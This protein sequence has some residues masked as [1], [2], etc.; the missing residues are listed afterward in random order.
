MG[1]MRNAPCITPSPNVLAI[2]SGTLHSLSETPVEGNLCP[3]ACWNSFV[4]L[5]DSIFNDINSENLGGGG[6]GGGEV[7][8][9]AVI[10]VLT[11]LFYVNSVWNKVQT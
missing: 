1:S 11:I 7:R 8:S 9:V 4:K 10:N 6:G 5:M 2:C 3:K